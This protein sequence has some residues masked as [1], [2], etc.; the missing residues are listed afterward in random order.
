M[1]ESIF[2]Q[3]TIAH[4]V[5]DFI[6]PPWKRM[7]EK[8]KPLWK[9]RRLWL[10]VVLHFIVAFIVMANPAWW[11]IALLI[12]ASHFIGDLVRYKWQHEYPVAAFVLDQLFHLMLITS[13]WWAINSDNISFNIPIPLYEIAGLLFV[14]RPTATIVQLFLSRW[15]PVKE[16]E[17]NK[18]L[19]NAG[20]WIGMLE[21]MLIFVFI[22]VGHWEGVGFLLA[23]KS[24][25]R[26]GDLRNS[27]E[28][29]LTE[30]ILVGTLMSFAI[31]IFTG[32]VV[33]SLIG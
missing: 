29:H 13:I 18:G 3:L 4:L 28:V 32:L 26:F 25:F 7:K 10:H 5:G 6:L 12:A 11:H 14:T 21:R 33:V 15:P 24:V 30:Y 20:L 2:I 23:A 9:S 17:K 1:T 22:L 19:V 16:I 8:G 31:A 27:K